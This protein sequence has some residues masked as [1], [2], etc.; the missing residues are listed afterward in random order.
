MV[1]SDTPP[2]LTAPVAP[3]SSSRALQVV[4]KLLQKPKPR[5]VT[6]TPP[7]PPSQICSE[8]DYNSD[9]KCAAVDPLTPKYDVSRAYKECLTT[10]C[11]PYE[12]CKAAKKKKKKKKKNK[13]DDAKADT[14]ADADTDAN[15]EA[16]AA[17][18]EDASDEAPPKAEED[19]DAGKDAEKGEGAK[20]TA[21]EGDAD[22]ASDGKDE[23]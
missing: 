8:S 6:L 16:D 14:E 4:K 13:A 12:C 19:A 1:T 17:G 7:K 10:K 18:G 20:D 21:G 23:L 9:A 2:S 11:Q 22:A 3:L 5:K 15:A